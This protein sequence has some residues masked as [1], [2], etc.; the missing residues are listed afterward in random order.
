M[1]LAQVR[2]SA[3]GDKLAESQNLNVYVS[4]NTSFTVGNNLCDAGIKFGKVYDTTTVL[5]PV[6]AGRKTRYVTV[7]MNTTATLANGTA[8]NLTQVLSLQ[9]VVPLYES[10][11]AHSYTD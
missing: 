4:A 1:L 10:E 3:S 6:V 8:T 5:C 9:E 11:S 2:I 7:M